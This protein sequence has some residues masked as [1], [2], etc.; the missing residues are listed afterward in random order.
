[1][2]KKLFTPKRLAIPPNDG[3]FPKRKKKQELCMILF[4]RTC[5]KKKKC[6]WAGVSNFCFWGFLKKNKE[7]LKKCLQG[8]KKG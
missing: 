2:K 4:A 8:E 7:L 3:A 5:K 1:M 6:T